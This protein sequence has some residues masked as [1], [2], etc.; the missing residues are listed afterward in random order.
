MVIQH[1][2]VP[3]EA[4]YSES[5]FRGGRADGGRLVLK[6]GETLSTDTYF[7]SFSYTVYRDFTDVS[8]V[9]AEVKFSGNIKLELCLYN[10]SESV[11]AEKKA[12][13]GSPAGISVSVELSGL[14]DGAFLFFRVYA[15]S[16]SVIYSGGYSSDTAPQDIECCVVMCTY[17]REEYALRNA[18]LLC[19]YPFSVIRKLLIIDNGKTLPSDK[20]PDDKAE[21]IPK[22]SRE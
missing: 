6:K 18:E 21:V 5:F 1:L 16:D 8:A 10:G 4:Q 3:I 2:I 22:C 12:S 15:L 11:L 7:N 17:R 19:S 14:P 9:S 13:S 20:F